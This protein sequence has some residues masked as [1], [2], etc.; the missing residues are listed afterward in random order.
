MVIAAAFQIPVYVGFRA[1][2]VFRFCVK[3]VYTV[4]HSVIG[5]DIRGKYETN[6][7][8]ICS[9]NQIEFTEKGVLCTRFSHNNLQDEKMC[10]NIQR[11]AQSR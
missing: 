7:P 3:L 6:K 5:E 4:E 1:R 2:H 11:D 10:E 9:L 8:G